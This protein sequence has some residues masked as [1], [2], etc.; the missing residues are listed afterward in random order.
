MIPL[1]GALVPL[2]VRK[3]RSHKPPSMHPPKKNP[4]ISIIE[5]KISDTEKKQEHS[6]LAE[7]EKLL[8]KVITG[9]TFII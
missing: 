7:N 3:L 8:V 4:Q 2:L 6:K 5:L 9:N 1:L